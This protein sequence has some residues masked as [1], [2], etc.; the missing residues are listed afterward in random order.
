MKSNFKT[1]NSLIYQILAYFLNIH[2]LYQKEIIFLVLTNFY[3][4][5]FYFV[6][7]NPINEFFYLRLSKILSIWSDVKVYYFH[8]LINKIFIIIR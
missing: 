8:L 2:F 4:Y 7:K 5:L 1:I 6:P 3:I